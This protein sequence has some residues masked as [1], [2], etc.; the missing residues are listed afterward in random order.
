MLYA[1]DRRIDC[2]FKT[3]SS[4]TSIACLDE[5]LLPWLFPCI[6]RL[7]LSS[8]RKSEGRVSFEEERMRWLCVLF[9]FF[10][11]AGRFIPNRDPRRLSNGSGTRR[12]VRDRR[13]P[14]WVA[15]DWERNCEERKGGRTDGR[16]EE[17]EGLGT[18]DVPE[19]PSARSPSVTWRFLEGQLNI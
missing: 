18:T 3:L 2:P 17:E 11:L 10:F 8:S 15:Q 9:F 1:G 7:L 4:F 6:C 14:R 19:S 13:K 16:V 12:D 5:N